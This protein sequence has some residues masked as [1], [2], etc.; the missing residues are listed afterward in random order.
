LP[1]IRII[2]DVALIAEDRGQGVCRPVPDPWHCALPRNP[3]V[4]L[5]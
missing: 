2:H 3:W 5:I 4:W 1:A